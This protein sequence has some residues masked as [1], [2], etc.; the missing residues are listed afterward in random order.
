MHEHADT[1]TPICNASSGAIARA[2][3]VA[4]NA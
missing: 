3:G 2:G 1:D 4:Q